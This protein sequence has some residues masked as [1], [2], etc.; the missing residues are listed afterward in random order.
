MSGHGQ[1]AEEAPAMSPPNSLAMVGMRGPFGFV[2]MGGMFTVLK[3]RQSLPE[4]R[5]VGWYE[6]PE[7]TVSMRADPKDLARDGIDV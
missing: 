1:V 3:V 5:N 4:G 2:T 7:G 6:H